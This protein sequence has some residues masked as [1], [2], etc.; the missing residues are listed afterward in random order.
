M[1]LCCTLV[2]HLIHSTPKFRNMKNL[3]IGVIL[4]AVIT[5][6]TGYF[7]VHHCYKMQPEARP[8]AS[9]NQQRDR[10]ALVPVDSLINVIPNIKRYRDLDPAQTKVILH[11]RESL[12]MFLDNYDRLVANE[13]E[14]TRLNDTSY[15]WLV[16]LYPYLNSNTHKIDFYLIPTVAHYKKGMLGSSTNPEIFDDI[17]D[18]CDSS[19][20]AAYYKKD[21]VSV[22][23]LGTVWP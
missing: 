7:L 14:I 1:K 22:Y 4:G 19:V 15:K 20:T 9:D 10:S 16:G 3:I 12:R 17:K 11:S 2:E 18:Y 6:G 23:D 5:A 8:T 13:S 21:F